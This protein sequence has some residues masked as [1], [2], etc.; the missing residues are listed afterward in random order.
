MVCNVMLVLLCLSYILKHISY[1]V[2]FYDNITTRTVKTMI[3]LNLYDE[4]R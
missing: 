1:G 2:Y 3:Y 4:T